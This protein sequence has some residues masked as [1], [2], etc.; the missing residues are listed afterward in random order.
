[1]V[2]RHRVIVFYL[3]AY[4]ISWIPGFTYAILYAQGSFASRVIPFLLLLAT[5]YG[6]TLAALLVL[7]LLRDPDEIRRFRR[8]L[9]TWRAGIGWYALTLILPLALWSLGA[10]LSAGTFGVSVAFVPAAAA[11]LPAILLANAGEEIGW[12]AFAFPHLL[13][14]LRPLSASLVF[15]VLWAGIHLPLYLTVLERFVILVP[16]FLGLSVIMAW[17]FLHTGQGVLL[18]LLFHGSLD[19]IQFVLPLEQGTHGTQMF[20]AIMGATI[21]V[22][23]FVIWRGGLR[24]DRSE[25]KHDAIM[26][27]Q[28][29]AS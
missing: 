15:G 12:R 19:T 4:A 2:S 27:V 14:R 5:S 25:G 10:L 24:L 16:L 22:A 26:Q 21:A 11:A 6:P 1:M 3:L 7:A 13:E 29:I 9:T 17:I 23:A 28:S 8:R 20:A 18:M